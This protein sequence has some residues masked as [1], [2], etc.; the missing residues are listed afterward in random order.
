MVDL[1]EIVKFYMTVGEWVS[2][3]GN[4]SASRLEYVNIKNLK[5][6]IYFCII[7]VEVSG[8]WLVKS[9]D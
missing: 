2:G 1:Q 5:I 9:E 3:M 4:S 6:A 8:I 7:S